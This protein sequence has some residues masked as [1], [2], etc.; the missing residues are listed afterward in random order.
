[1]Y[2]RPGSLICAKHVGGYYPVPP[3][4]SCP[5]I[6]QG[7]T[8]SPV[9]EGPALR[10]SR[11]GKTVEVII[12]IQS[13]YHHVQYIHNSS[14]AFREDTRQLGLQAPHIPNSDGN[15]N[16]LRST[17]LA[18]IAWFKPCSSLP[19]GPWQ[20]IPKEILWTPLPSTNISY[21]ILSLYYRISNLSKTCLS[22]SC[23]FIISISMRTQM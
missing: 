17:A 6:H 1:M 11:W 16:G 9:R 19:G 5:R 15:I 10:C 3:P 2:C 18:W 13:N 8:K 21:L 7:T 14:K 20:E 22:S 4:A 23:L 12:T